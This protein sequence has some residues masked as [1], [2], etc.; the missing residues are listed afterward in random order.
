MATV[1]NNNNNITFYA[2]QPTTWKTVVEVVVEESEGGKVSNNKYKYSRYTIIMQ[3]PRRF[4]SF[5][6]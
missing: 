1:N 5:H 2:R 3:S 4:F 6:Y